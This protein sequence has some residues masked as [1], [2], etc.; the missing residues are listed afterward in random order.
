MM[1]AST[2]DISFQ[3]VLLSLLLIVSVVSESLCYISCW[4]I[5]AFV[6]IGLFVET[7]SSQNTRQHQVLTTTNAGMLQKQ[8]T[9]ISPIQLNTKLTAGPSCAAEGNKPVTRLLEISL[10]H[11]EETQALIPFHPASSSVEE[12]GHQRSLSNHCC[13]K[14]TPHL[15]LSWCPPPTSQSSFWG[16]P[17]HLQKN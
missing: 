14:L 5:Y 1:S 4:T 12:E 17:S 6:T 16:S 10:Y 8:L 15:H 9:S 13:W 11:T 7:S 3:D 2:Q